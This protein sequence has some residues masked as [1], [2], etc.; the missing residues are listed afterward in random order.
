M[1]PTSV[2]LT[3]QSTDDATGKVFAA[4]AVTYLGQDTNGLML[5]TNGYGQYAYAKLKIWWPSP[6]DIPAWFRF[7]NLS[8][9]VM[10]QE[11]EIFNWVSPW[12]DL[13]A[14]NVLKHDFQLRLFTHAYL[15]DNNPKKV[16]LEVTVETER[17]RKS[18]EIQY[19]FHD[20]QERELDEEH[21]LRFHIS[22][23][24]VRIIIRQLDYYWAD[25][26]SC[27]LRVKGGVLLTADMTPD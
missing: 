12:T 2:P 26:E 15:N 19:E 20:T 6:I 22:G 17:G 25:I 13:G 21:L 14:K 3:Y 18:R 4:P 7:Q 16:K 8:I 9:E 1:P 24:R 27:W 11:T 23:R 5:L 10:M